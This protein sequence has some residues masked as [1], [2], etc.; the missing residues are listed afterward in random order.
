MRKLAATA[1]AAA[2]SGS[3]LFLGTGVAS[4]APPTSLGTPGTANCEAQTTAFF[5][6]ASKEQN[7]EPGIGNLSK[8]ASLSVKEVKEIF[9][10][11]CA[12]G[13]PF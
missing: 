6:Q 8:A 9:R 13:E 3:M 2:I 12:T 4:A 10:A 7:D 5:A 11:Y 1:A